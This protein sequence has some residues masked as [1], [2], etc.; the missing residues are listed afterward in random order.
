[1]EKENITPEEKLLRIIEN[2]DKIKNK[3]TPAFGKLKGSFNFKKTGSLLDWLKAHKDSFKQLNLR[4]INRIVIGLAAVLT[5]YGIFDFIISNIGL[6]KHFDEFVEE[7][8]AS[9]L[10]QNQL[11]LV[12]ANIADVLAAQKRRNIFTFTSVQPED[13]RQAEVAGA[14]ASTALVNLKLVGIIWSDKPQV[15]IEDT[16]QQKTY[17][18]GQGD[19]VGKLQIKKILRDKVVLG[20]GEQEWDLR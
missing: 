9:T 2:P 11:P 13:V 19:E 16:K 20:T 14:E 18:L 17:L 3:A 1:M 10:T 5:L 15:M 12:E 4:T 6:K 8:A 7:A